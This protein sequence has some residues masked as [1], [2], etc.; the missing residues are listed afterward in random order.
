[1]RNSMVMNIAKIIDEYAPQYDI[2]TEDDE[3]MTALKE[4][5]ASLSPANKI[6]FVLYAETGSV[7]EVAKHIGVSHTTIYYQIKQIQ[8]EIKD[9]LLKNNEDILKQYGD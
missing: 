6:I 1:M 5:V 8:Q 4:A 2:M 3:G 9:W 7:R